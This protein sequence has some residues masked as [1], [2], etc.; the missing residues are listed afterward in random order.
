M[1]PYLLVGN[2][3]SMKAVLGRK[4]LIVQHAEKLL[5]RV[6]FAAFSYQDLADLVEI[7]KPAIHHHFATKEDLGL[8]VIAYYEEHLDAIV[9]MVS[10]QPGGPGARLRAFISA[11][12]E[13]DS[14]GEICPLGAL[15][16]HFET[17][18]PSMKQATI[19]LTERMRS[20][21][22]GLVTEARSSG[23]VKDW[24]TAQEQA[25][26]IMSALQGGRQQARALGPAAF[27]DV[28]RSVERALFRRAPSNRDSGPD[29]AQL[30]GSSTY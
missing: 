16:V 18:P 11:G 4:T 6:G 26:L 14:S 25:A 1:T 30:D 15:Q 7:S 2:I 9:N 12:E 28:S 21:V 27:D 20:W 23:E 17:F 8:R 13:Q 10:G 24:G 19:D 3:S 5:R 29:G 22:T